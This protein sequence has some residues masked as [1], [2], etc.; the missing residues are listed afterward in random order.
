MYFSGQGKLLV[1]NAANGIPGV[2]RNVGNV[3]ELSVQLETEIF[4]H[5]ESSSGQRLPDLRL[6]KSKGA[7]FNA[8]LQD[9]SKENL[10]LVLYGTSTVVAAGTVTSSTPEIQPAGVI[11]GDYLRTKYQKISSVVI[12]D[13]ATS[14]ATLVAG[15]H[16]VIDSADH[17]T[18]KI[19]NPVSFTQPFKISYT[20]TS[21]TSTNMFTSATPELWLRFEGL[22][23]ADSN[24]PVLVELFRS[25]PDPLK[26]LDLITDELAVFELAGSVLYDATKTNDA[27]LGTFGR[28][29]QI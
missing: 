26:Q 4:E 28:V 25:T 21:V 23:T 22:N 14:P 1:A 8:K 17:G 12:T 10:A 9:F 29:V 13:S 5:K 16:Y 20:Y 19:I 27:L 15:T 18:I 7:K 6:I 3:S 24:R 2:F 11:S